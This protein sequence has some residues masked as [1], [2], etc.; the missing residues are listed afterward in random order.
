MVEISAGQLDELFSALRMNR[1]EVGKACGDRSE[2]APRRWRDSGKM[3]KK[4][5]I[6]LAR[7]LAEKT[8]ALEKTP[9]Q[10]QAITMIEEKLKIPLAVLAA[11]GSA[12][13]GN[14]R[15]VLSLEDTGTK[16][17]FYVPDFQQLTLDQK[18]QLLQ[19]A[20]LETLINEIGRRG[21][22]VQLEP[23]DGSLK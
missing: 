11:E 2:F 23:K 14:A 21:F 15:S 18:N 8:Q 16:G 1:K 7:L 3:P 12:I 5:L 10:K 22:K 20:T 17:T 6:T 9:T 13:E 4:H 19:F